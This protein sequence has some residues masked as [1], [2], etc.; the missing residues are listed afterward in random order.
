MKN[1]ASSPFQ[2]PFPLGAD[3]GD[4]VPAQKGFPGKHPVPGANVDEPA[5]CRGKRALTA[6]PAGPR[7]TPLCQIRSRP[8]ETLDERVSGVSH[9]RSHFPH[10][11][12]PM[13]NR[14][15][16]FSVVGRKHKGGRREARAFEA[17]MPVEKATERL[18]VETTSRTAVTGVWLFCSLN[19]GW[20]NRPCA[21]QA[22][23]LRE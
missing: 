14:F 13:V 11:A 5:T 18:E 20:R 2:V 19:V 1:G 21:N 22:Y 8:A 9:L 23:P 4:S 10:G 3:F 6:A 12:P 16:L 17:A 15:L 7:E